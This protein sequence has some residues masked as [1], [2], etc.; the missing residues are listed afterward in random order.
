MKETKYKGLTI[1]HPVTTP[2]EV[3]DIC[4]WYG[5][6]YHIVEIDSDFGSLERSQQIIDSLYE[7]M[8]R[9]NSEHSEDA[10]SDILEYIEECL[11]V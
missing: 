11:C 4:D 5:T 3:K 8:D 6:T 7:D 2:E 9:F 1:Q 10:V